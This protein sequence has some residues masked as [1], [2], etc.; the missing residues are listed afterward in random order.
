[1]AENAKVFVAEKMEKVYTTFF[2]T[3][4][5]GWNFFIEFA[6]PPLTISFSVTYFS[7]QQKQSLEIFW[8]WTEII[9]SFESVFQ[10]C[11]DLLRVD[12]S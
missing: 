4:K 5:K 7:D 12:K 8:F 11:E 3:D 10:E 2:Y 1:M 6:N 9:R